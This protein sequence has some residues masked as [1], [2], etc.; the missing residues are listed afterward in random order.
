MHI[1][2]GQHIRE[3]LADLKCSTLLCLLGHGIE[4]ALHHRDVVDPVDRQLGQPHG[5][6]QPHGVSERWTFFRRCGA[7][8]Q[9][10]PTV[11]GDTA[12]DVAITV[13]VLIA[14]AVVDAQ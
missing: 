4:G 12:D 9:C 1:R 2:Q 5:V 14:I 7:D 13:V 11:F 10:A 6:P 8:S 3:C